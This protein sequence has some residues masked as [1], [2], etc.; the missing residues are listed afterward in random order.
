MALVCKADS[1]VHIRVYKVHVY[2]I[3][4]MRVDSGQKYLVAAECR[5]AQRTKGTS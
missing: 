2:Q 5:Q 1:Q 3:M 4:L